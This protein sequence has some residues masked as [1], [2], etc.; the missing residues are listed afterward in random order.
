M[1]FYILFSM[2]YT[3][4]FSILQIF[5]HPVLMEVGE[6]SHAATGPVMTPSAMSAVCPTDNST[7]SDTCTTVSTTNRSDKRMREDA[8][9]VIREALRQLK[10]LAST[11]DTADDC[12]SF[13]TVVAND[14]RQ[15]TGETKIYAEKLIYD[16]LFLAKLGRLSSTSVVKE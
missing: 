13:A 7:R 6:T 16:V 11:Q 1:Y 3:C 12:T 15:L 10:G 9:D 2:H 14:L 5:N 8:D 4:L